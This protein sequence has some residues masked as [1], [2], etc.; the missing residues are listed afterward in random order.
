M[1][2]KNHYGLQLF[3]GDTGIVWPD[4]EGRLQAWFQ[5]PEGGLWPVALSM[6]PAHDTAYAV[7]VHQAQ[8]SEFA[9]VLFLLPLQDNRILSREL[10]YTGLT[11]AR[12]KLT[13]ADPASLLAGAVRRRAVRYS[14]L[15][16]RLWGE[17]G[18]EM[19]LWEK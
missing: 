5:R 10:V 16:A 17:E 12:C 7:T 11:R 13:L 8:G 4:E 1:I 6:L 15:T 18:E 9:E 2:R 3:N 19:T 14:G